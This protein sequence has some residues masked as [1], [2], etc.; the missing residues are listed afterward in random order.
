MLSQIISAA[1]TLAQNFEELGINFNYSAFAIS[2]LI[3][4]L[5][6]LVVG[7]AFRSVGVYVMSKKQGAFHAVAFLRAVFRVR[8]TRKAHRAG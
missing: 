1:Y 3:S 5:L 8:S 4:S 2:A 6:F 7:F